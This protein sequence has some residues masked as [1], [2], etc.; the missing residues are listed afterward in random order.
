MGGLMPFAVSYPDPPL[1]IYVVAVFAVH[2]WSGGDNLFGMLVEESS[3]P[4]ERTIGNNQIAAV[5]HQE[6]IPTTVF[7]RVVSDEAYILI[8]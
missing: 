4:T 1:G 7:A 3:P 2:P 5:C 8:A 6:H